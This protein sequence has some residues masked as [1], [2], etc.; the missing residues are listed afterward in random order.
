[1]NTNGAMRNAKESTSSL[2][3]FTRRMF[4][5]IVEW[6]SGKGRG[7][8]ANGCRSART[9]TFQYQA[10]CRT[11]VCTARSV[12]GARHSS[13][14]NWIQSLQQSRWVYE[15]NNTQRTQRMDASARCQTDELGSAW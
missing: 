12:S 10:V 15:Q 4:A 14:H 2:R 8:E 13:Y 5:F 9:A 7:P 1:M 11:S 3:D 6:S